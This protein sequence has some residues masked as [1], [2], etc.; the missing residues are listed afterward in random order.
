MVALSVTVSEAL[1]NRLPTP[2][3]ALP[4]AKACPRLCDAAVVLAAP[5][6][7][8]CVCG[9]HILAY[10]GEGGGGGEERGGGEVGW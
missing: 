4:A 7:T 6:T 3:L 1:R 10:R 8:Q 2:S 5:L 9:D